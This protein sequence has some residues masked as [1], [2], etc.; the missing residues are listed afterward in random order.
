MLGEALVFFIENVL[1]WG[2]VYIIVFMGCDTPAIIF[3]GFGVFFFYWLFRFVFRKQGVDRMIW[4]YVINIILTIMLIYYF[5]TGSAKGA[6]KS[7]RSGLNSL[8]KNYPS[9]EPY[10]KKC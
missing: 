4:L 3:T 8:A 5:F 10:V 1:F 9:M 2:F 6:Q 7:I